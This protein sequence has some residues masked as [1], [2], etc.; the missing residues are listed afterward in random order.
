MAFGAPMGSQSVDA[1]CES[2]SSEFPM[3]LV[4]EGCHGV[5]SVLHSKDRGV[6]GEYKSLGCWP[7]EG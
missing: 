7:K 6:G 4:A 2:G 5:V 1:L 3:G